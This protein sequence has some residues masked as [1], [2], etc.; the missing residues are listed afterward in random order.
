MKCVC[1][2]GGLWGKCEIKTEKGEYKHTKV[3]ICQCQA[4]DGFICV[5][6][7]SNKWL[8]GLLNGSLMMETPLWICYTLLIYIFFFLLQLPCSSPQR[9]CFFF[10]FA[11]AFFFFLLHLALGCIYNKCCKLCILSWIKGLQKL[12]R[13]IKRE[14]ADIYVSLRWVYVYLDFAGAGERELGF[15]W[16]TGKTRSPKMNLL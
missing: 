8:A 1:A 12:E 3:K 16:N 2:W 14:N 15:P 5:N 11:F 4:N 10:S 9:L 6:R 13:S 7:L